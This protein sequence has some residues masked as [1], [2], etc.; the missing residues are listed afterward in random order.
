M[1]P[2]AEAKKN[3]VDN[4]PSPEEC[5]PAK[6]RAKVEKEVEPKKLPPKVPDK[7]F[8]V[9]PKKLP[10]KIKQSHKDSDSSLT[11]EKKQL[12]YR[13]LARAIEQAAKGIPECSEAW[14][15]ITKAKR[16]FWNIEGYSRDISTHTRDLIA[17]L[18]PEQLEDQEIQRLTGRL[19]TLTRN[20]QLA[21]STCQGNLETAHLAIRRAEDIL[22]HKHEVVE[23][24]TDKLFNFGEVNYPEHSS[25]CFDCFD[26]R[27]FIGDT[28][29]A[30]LPDYGLTEAVVVQLGRANFVYITP[31]R[32]GRTF[33]WFGIH[34]EVLPPTDS[35]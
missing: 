5:E 19:Q 18:T 4:K 30:T 6:K 21:N 7:F 3:Q 10:P 20:L 9:D 27:I 17:K 2:S 31:R 15:Y 33:C 34:V 8:T 13:Q 25:V 12:L 23:E 22:V 28:V 35:E 1:S 32:S 11:L 26:N 16:I 14:R 24:T 29:L